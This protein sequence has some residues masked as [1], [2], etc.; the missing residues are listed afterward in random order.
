[1]NKYL[2]ISSSLSQL[3]APPSQSLPLYNLTKANNY[4]GLSS[5]STSCLQFT[6]H[7]SD[8]CLITLLSW[9]PLCYVWVH[10]LYNLSLDSLIHLWIISII[11]RP[12]NVKM[13]HK[14]LSKPQSS[15]TSS[16]PVIKWLLALTCDVV[17]TS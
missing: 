10:S 2:L 4:R 8:L 11:D 5:F 7:Q 3:C 16:T 6:P 14:F 9:L 17:K 13:S 1:M 15:L 12:M